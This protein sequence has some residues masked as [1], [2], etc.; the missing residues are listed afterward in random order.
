VGTKQNTE[1][2]I[3]YNKPDKPFKDEF[4]QYE[5]KGIENMNKRD[6]AEMIVDMRLEISLHR[7]NAEWLD[8]LAMLLRDEPILF[9]E[10]EDGYDT[11]DA[12]GEKEM[13]ERYQK[14]KERII[15][16]YHA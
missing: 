13:Y 1:H 5:L 9:K 3:Y 16:R 7:N 11:E 12:L 14:E 4:M 6:I 10:D 2:M 15:K 8:S